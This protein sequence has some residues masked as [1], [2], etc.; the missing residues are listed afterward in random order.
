MDG[1]VYYNGSYPFGAFGIVDK[2][3]ASP[4]ASRAIVKVSPGS[5]TGPQTLMPNTLGI[6][7]GPL[8][9]LM[10]SLQG[11]QNKFN[12]IPPPQYAL[13]T[14]RLIMRQPMV[15][16]LYASKVNKILSSSW[17]VKSANKEKPATQQAIDL[18]RDMMVPQR[19]HFYKEAL[20]FLWSGVRQ[21]E[22]IY[23]PHPSG[24]KYWLRLKPLLPDWTVIYRDPFG[25]FAGIKTYHTPLDYSGRDDEDLS[26]GFM[27]QSKS[28]I[29]SNDGE[30]G[31]FYGFS[32]CDNI[33]NTFVEHNKARLKIGQTR[34]KIAGSIVK[35]YHPQGS[36]EFDG[37]LTSNEDI[38]DAI[39]EALTVGE[40][41]VTI[42]CGSEFGEVVATEKGV[43]SL[44]K[45]EV[46][47]T[48]GY[49]DGIKSMIEEM[50][51]WD[52]EFCRGW[53][54]PERSMIEASK[55]GSRADSGTASDVAIDDLSAIEGDIC[56]QLNHG[57]DGVVGVVDNI[58]LYNRG[59]SEVGSV[60][61]E[62]NPLV[63][64][65]RQMEKEILIALMS[66]TGPQAAEA[67][68]R[69]DKEQ[70]YED[71]D[72][73]M[74]EDFDLAEFQAKQDEAEEKKNQGKF[75]MPG[76]NPDDNPLGKT[77][78]KPVASLRPQD[79]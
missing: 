53:Y 76:I 25:D 2:V 6:Y 34:S 58:L 17:T 40:N 12:Y 20:R 10:R 22:N 21:W 15:A 1:Q 46:E 78:S 7:N 51:Y 59:P 13:S 71:L 47:D 48:S 30:G 69:L 32:R 39:G 61:I 63:D 77:K 35:I 29:V 55:S 68:A 27:D 50:G 26:G 16:N 73:A 72:L 64:Q 36:S 33:Y 24:V 38:A 45:I 8:S 56:S 49:S 14:Y 3:V 18:V 52:K 31:N 11:G 5:Q 44:W 62:P 57:R 79:K 60:I 19:Y 42:P 23:N 43:E 67:W 65:K 28:F 9:S 75:G 66:G 74:D 54:T 70:T 4:L 41:Y 37:V